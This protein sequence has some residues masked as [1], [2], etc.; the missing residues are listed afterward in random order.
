MFRTYCP[1]TAG[2]GGP[3]C[4]AARLSKRPKPGDFFLA[5]T[6][7]PEPG[8]TAHCVSAPFPSAL[9]DSVLDR[10]KMPRFE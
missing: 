8:C 2:W 9:S 5:A 6:F 4:G 10:T 3:R 1:D 7:P